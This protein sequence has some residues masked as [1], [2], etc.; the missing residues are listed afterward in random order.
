MAWH[1]PNV[2]RFETT[3]LANAQPGRFIRHP[4]DEVAARRGHDAQPSHREA[5]SFEAVTLRSGH[6]ANHSV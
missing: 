2:N 5:D 4:A 1:R 3:C 6:F